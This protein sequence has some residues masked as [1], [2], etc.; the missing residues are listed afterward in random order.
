MI[1]AF[2][3]TRVCLSA[4]WPTVVVSPDRESLSA[5]F[6]VRH[7]ISSILTSMKFK[8]F[9]QSSLTTCKEKHEDRVRLRIR[10]LHR[11]D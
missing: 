6:K 3:H 5:L 2:L 4:V 8:W 1:E 11:E 9:V 10:A 7:K